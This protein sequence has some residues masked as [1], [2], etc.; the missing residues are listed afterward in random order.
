MTST[1]FSQFLLFN[2]CNLRTAKPH[3]K[4]YVNKKVFV[5]KKHKILRALCF[6]GSVFVGVLRIQKWGLGLCGMN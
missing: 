5:E 2:L 4:E 6:D 1:C 3:E